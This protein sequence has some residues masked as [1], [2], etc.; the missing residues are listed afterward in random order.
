MTY[1][2]FENSAAGYDL[3]YYLIYYVWGFSENQVVLYK[4]TGGCAFSKM[5]EEFNSLQELTFNGKTVKI[6]SADALILLVDQATFKVTPEALTKFI[7]DLEGIGIEVYLRTLF[8]FE[9]CL[10]TFR[11]IG[12]NYCGYDNQFEKFKALRQVLL[13]EQQ[14]IAY[15]SF[16]MKYPEFSSWTLEH[17]L[18][19]VLSQYLF[20]AMPCFG[21]K[22]LLGYRK[23]PFLHAFY[24]NEC[25]SNSCRNYCALKRSKC[26]CKGAINGHN[27]I[28]LYFNSCLSKPLWRRCDPALNLSLY[29]LLRRKSHATACNNNTT[30]SYFGS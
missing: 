18:K 7:M 25:F 13:A 28:Y 19:I 20:R 26:N 12:V 17:T 6:R 8:S 15:D 24:F 5:I 21:Y 3:Y 9:Q 16:T 29:D 11:D 10:Y 23:E 30:T 2:L 4:G 1:L 22:D 14:T 27:L